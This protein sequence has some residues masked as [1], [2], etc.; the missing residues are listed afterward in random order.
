MQ[1][2]FLIC[3]LDRC[4]SNISILKIELTFNVSLKLK[5]LDLHII[6]YNK[7]TIKDWSGSSYMHY[8]KSFKGFLLLV[9]KVL[10]YQKE[11]FPNVEFRVQNSFPSKW[12]SWINNRRALSIL[13]NDIEPVRLNILVPELSYA[14]TGGPLS[15]LR[16]ARLA[17]KAGIKVRLINYSDGGISFEQL[18]THLKKYEGLE[19]FGEHVEHVWNAITTLINTNSRDIFMG[20]VYY[21]ASV[22]SATQKLLKNPNIIYFIQDYECIFFPHDSDLIEVAETYDAPHFAIFSTEFLR[23]YFR[24]KKLGV[25]RE[26]Q[27]VGDE[28]SFA[29]MPAIKPAGFR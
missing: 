2:R 6:S 26:N 4:S 19:D 9:S 23:E 25:Y 16:F 17:V 10:Q 14:L 12:E 21:T 1:I 20:T 18:A 8:F 27:S 28:R 29:S 22:A 7:Y 13:I 5:G 24:V 15:I 3:K 11:M